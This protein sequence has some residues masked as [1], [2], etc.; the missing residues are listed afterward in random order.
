MPAV[1]VEVLALDAL[2]GTSL[3]LSIDVL[4][5][6]NQIARGQG[7]AP[8]F[9]VRVVAASGQSA[10]RT[11]AGTPSPW[12][13]RSIRGA[14]PRV[15][16]VPG[17]GIVDASEV[18][19]ALAR[20]EL[21]RMKARLRAAHA[22]GALVTASCTGTFALAE[23]GLLDGRS[24]TTTWWLASAFRARF[25]RVA[26]TEEQMLVA[27][28]RLVTAGAA[29]AQADLALALVSCFAGPDVAETTARYLLLDGRASPAR[30]LLLAH[31]TATDPVL[32]RAER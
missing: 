27:S 2:M 15:V 14:D 8:H 30:H 23:S 29:F 28:G 1:T 5:T 7:R 10:V 31:L 13:G 17:L 20:P 26:L 21:Q 19:A 12:T 6:A 22:G 25:P 18:D 16:V 32:A 4:R 3:G 24:A 9:D 11:A